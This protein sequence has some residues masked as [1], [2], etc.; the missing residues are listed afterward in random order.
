[1]QRRRETEERE[2]RMI[3]TLCGVLACH[4]GVPV[5]IVR[6]PDREPGS[7]GGCDAVIMR[8]DEL[9]AVEHTT[10]HSQVKKPFLI[11]QL[12]AARPIIVPIVEEAFPRSVVR[13]GLPVSPDLSVKKIGQ[14]AKKVGNLS[15][16]ALRG[17]KKDERVR[18]S[19]PGLPADVFAE[20]IFEP[21][22]SALCT[23]FP[24]VWGRD[25]EDFT[26]DDLCRAF[27]EKRRQAAECSEPVIL[28]LETSG[29]LNLPAI[30]DPYQR[31]LARESVEA[32]QEIYVGTSQYDPAL[33]I[34]L[35]LGD[36]SP[37]GQPELG[38]FIGYRFPPGS[39]EF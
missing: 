1:M 27:A 35:K 21:T 17:A 33:I 8:G 28:L 36:R 39:Q 30:I 9:W 11:K 31:A 10:I 7:G 29:Y 6:R 4:E 2:D 32:F 38:Q 34:P 37:V 13:I 22:R 25:V 26:A 15:V 5:T 23:V 12:E 20:R 18:F 19:V 16:D 14:I 24:A 3:G